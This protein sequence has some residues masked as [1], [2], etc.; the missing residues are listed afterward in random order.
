[1]ARHRS[2]EEEE[3]DPEATF[4]TVVAT[5]VVLGVVHVLTGPDHLS[6]LIALSAGGGCRSFFLG[7]RWGIGHTSGLVVIAAIFFA[8][9]GAFDLEKIG[10]YGET[11]VGFFMIALGLWTAYN[12]VKLHN[13]GAAHAALMQQAARDGGSDR[14]SEMQPMVL[15]MSGLGEEV[16]EEEGRG[17]GDR[18]RV[19]CTTNVCGSE[20]ACRAQGVIALTTGL[21]HG[22]AGPGQILGVLPAV[23]IMTSG[24]EDGDGGGQGWMAVTYLLIFGASS[25]L[26][27]GLFAAFYGE[28]TT[29]CGNARTVNLV[30]GIFS[31]SMST[32]IGVVWLY[33]L[34]QGEEI[35]LSGVPLFGR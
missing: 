2:L 31:A 15:E 19:L 24:G 13:S 35:D 3:I 27:M 10:H 30:I 7:I 26:V 23:V 6:A 17:G 9:D 29:W 11:C 21:V 25:T 14:D 4:G 34:L 12:A 33:F 1:M 8:L 28:V 5:S 32:L 20:R 16:V 18:T 22:I